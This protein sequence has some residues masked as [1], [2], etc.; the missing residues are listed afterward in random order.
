MTDG[1][2]AL[3]LDDFFDFYRRLNPEKFS[4]SVEKYETDLTPELFNPHL[5]TLS[6]DMLQDDFE[7]F[8]RRT[9]CRL[10]CPNINPGTGP[11][12]GGDGKTDAETFPVSPDIADKWYVGDG[13]NGEDR[14]AFA[15][16][17]KKNWSSK[18]ESDVTGIVGT[19]RGFT[20]IYLVLP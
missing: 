11:N 12:G 6:A 19:Q 17:V 13:N 16:S 5:A 18:A 2:N 14:W 7:R 20:R 1:Q 15:I 9:A 8:V 10:I 4:D 3:P